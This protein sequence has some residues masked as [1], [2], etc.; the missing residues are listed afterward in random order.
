MSIP[1]WVLAT[2]V[3]RA[4]GGTSGLLMMRSLKPVASEA[5]STAPMIT[6]TATAGTTAG[7]PTSFSDWNALAVTTFGGDPT[8]APQETPLYVGFVQASVYDAVVGI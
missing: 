4:A 7:D 3:S 5:S 8:K 6:S 2:I 1:S